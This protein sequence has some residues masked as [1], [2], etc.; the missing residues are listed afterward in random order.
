MHFHKSLAM[1][2]W[3]DYYLINPGVIPSEAM[4]LAL[5]EKAFFLLIEMTIVTL[6]DFLRCTYL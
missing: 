4:N 5:E 3:P 6:T 1:K 2:A